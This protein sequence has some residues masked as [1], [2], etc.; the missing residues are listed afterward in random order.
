MDEDL[1][2]HVSEA[3]QAAGLPPG[4]L[5]IWPTESLA[6]VDHD[7]TRRAFGRLRDRGIAIDHFGTG[8]LSTS[9]LR[10]LPFDKLKT[11]REFVADVHRKADSQAIWG[12]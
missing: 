9:A 4:R 12:R 2:P 5:E 1:D 11:H 6:T 8:Y 7:H 3:L 10:R